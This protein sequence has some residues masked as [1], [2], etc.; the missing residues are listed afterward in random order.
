MLLLLLWVGLMHLLALDLMMII[1]WRGIPVVRATAES[2]R[3]ILVGAGAADRG[4]LC[5][6]GSH[7]EQCVRFIRLQGL[8]LTIPSIHKRTLGILELWFARTAVPII[9][10]NNCGE[11]KPRKL[12]FCDGNIFPRVL[13]RE[14]E[15][16]TPLRV[17]IH[18]RGEAH[19]E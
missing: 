12:A 1:G 16:V 4:C 2:T 11:A 10:R 13:E 17:Q 9:A 14:E 3:A 19:L 5:L 6:I 18:V 8:R 15:N 7:C